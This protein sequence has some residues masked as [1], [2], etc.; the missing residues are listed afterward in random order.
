[1]NT[2]SH[3]LRELGLFRFGFP[4]RKLAI[5]VDQSSAPIKIVLETIAQLNEAA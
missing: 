4:K 1:V 5:K 3:H 2:V